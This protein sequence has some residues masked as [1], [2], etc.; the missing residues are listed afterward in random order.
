MDKK[1]EQLQAVLDELRLENRKIQFSSVVERLAKKIE[2][3]EERLT[4][5]ERKI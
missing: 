4:N 2:N 3:I 1:I 5:I